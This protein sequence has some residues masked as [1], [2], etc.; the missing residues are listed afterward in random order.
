MRS[1]L[2]LALTGFVFGCGGTMEMN[3]PTAEQLDGWKDEIRAADQAFSDA[4]QRDGLSQWSS[5]FAPDGAV[6]R[7][8][9]GVV[10]GREAIQEPLD[11]ALSAGAIKSLTWVPDFVEVSKA[12]DLGYSIGTYRSVGVT[13]DGVEMESLGV[14][15]SVWRRQDD[16]RWLAELDLGNVVSPPQPVETPGSETG[17]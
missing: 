14:Y 1:S 12:G 9:E 16:G 2:V 15:V 5:Y 13:P 6:V 17:Q 10:R 4:M 11:A 7:E 8:G 3:E